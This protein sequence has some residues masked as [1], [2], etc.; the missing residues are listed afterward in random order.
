MS[1]MKIVSKGLSVSKDLSRISRLL[2][3][4]HI[5]IAVD[6]LSEVLES[7]VLHDVLSSNASLYYYNDIREA[8][9]LSLLPFPRGNVRIS[10]NYKITLEEV[11]A[12]CNFGWFNKKVTSKVFVV[13]KVECEIHSSEYYYKFL[14]FKKV[15]STEE[16]IAEIA[17]Y[18]NG[19]WSPA[20]IEHLLPVA[21]NLPEP[22]SC[23]IIALGSVAEIDGMLQTP[24]ISGDKKCRLDLAKA[25]GSGWNADCLFLMVKYIS[26]SSDLTSYEVA[27][28]PRL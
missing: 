10:V 13:P 25:N 24:L 22:P 18:E 19:E 23:P 7:G 17:E 6:R 1:V 21:R 14:P 11:I 26:S 4:F 28:G 8:L 12:T 9:R 20:R 3:K 5:T 27:H 16:V 2:E 15:V